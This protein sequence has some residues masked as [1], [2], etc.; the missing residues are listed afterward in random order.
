MT[1]PKFN[2]RDA[3]DAETREKTLEAFNKENKDMFN[4]LDTALADM[5]KE[6]DEV[7]EMEIVS[8]TQFHT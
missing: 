3:I 6:P 2:Y 5:A 8:S 4:S 7:T 1:D